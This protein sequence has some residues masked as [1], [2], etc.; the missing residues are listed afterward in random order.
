[1]A[2]RGGGGYWREGAYEYKA[3]IHGGTLQQMAAREFQK[4]GARW[5]GR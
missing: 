3:G 4:E 1:M 5:K 2:E